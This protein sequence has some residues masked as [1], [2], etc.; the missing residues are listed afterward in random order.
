MTRYFFSCPL[1][2]ISQKSQSLILSEVIFHKISR[3]VVVDLAFE[4]LNFF[5][6]IFDFKSMIQMASLPWGCWCAGGIEGCFVA[7]GSHF[8]N[9]FIAEAMAKTTG[10]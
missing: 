5:I 4:K 9:H 8:I 6:I 2:A 10:S 7:A 3:C 1:F